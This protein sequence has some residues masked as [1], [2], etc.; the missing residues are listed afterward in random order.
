MKA[1]REVN[2]GDVTADLDLNTIAS[3]DDDSSSSNI[4]SKLMSIAQWAFE[5][6]IDQ[7]DSNELGQLERALI[8]AVRLTTSRKIAV[9]GGDGENVATVERQRE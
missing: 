2:E 4:K 5:G 8:E 6:N 7:L 1:E 9:K 3:G